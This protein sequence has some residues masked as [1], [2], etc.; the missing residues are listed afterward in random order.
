ML[1]FT[2]IGIILSAL[3]IATLSAINTYGLTGS[4]SAA[5]TTFAVSIV[6]SFIVQGLNVG[7]GLADSLGSLGKGFGELFSGDGV[8]GGAGLDG[9]TS[10]VEHTLEIGV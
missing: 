7:Q 10:R 3:I 6:T 4:L 8:L 1:A 2:G 5:L 9:G